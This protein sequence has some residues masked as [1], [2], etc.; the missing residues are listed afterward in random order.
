L[1][2]IKLAADCAASPRDCAAGGR[3]KLLPVVTALE[4]CEAA[5]DVA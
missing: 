4:S 1:T 2:G 3:Y 5:A